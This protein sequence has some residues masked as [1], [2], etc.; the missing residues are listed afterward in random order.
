MIV[1]E[2][3]LEKHPMICYSCDKLIEVG[4]KYEKITTHSKQKILVHTDCICGKG[5]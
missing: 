4:Q 1:T 5:E 2:K 3:D